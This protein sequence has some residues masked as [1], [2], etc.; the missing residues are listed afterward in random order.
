MAVPGARVPVAGVTWVAVAP[1]A[2][3]Q[4]VLRSFMTRQLTDL[5]ERG[6]A[7]AALWASEG[8]IYQRFG[9]GPAAWHLS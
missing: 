1:T 7:V 9:Y 4:G 5:H 6:T 8:A 2:R 3:R